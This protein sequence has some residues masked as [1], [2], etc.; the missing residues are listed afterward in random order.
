MVN[1]SQGGYTHDEVIQMLKKNRTI[2]YKYELYDNNDRNLGTFN[3]VTSARIAFNSEST[4]MWSGTIEFRKNELLNID[5]IDYRI[6]P[7]LCILAPNGEWLNYQLCKLIISTPSEMDEYMCSAEMYGLEL[8]LSSDKLASR[9]FIPKGSRYTDIIRSIANN[10][11]LINT[12]IPGSSN[13]TSEDIEYSIGTSKIE[14]INNLADAI[15]YTHVYSDNLG[16]ICC[17]PKNNV[18]DCM[19]SHSYNADENS[20]IFKGKSL[21][22][23][24]FDIPNRFVRFIENPESEVMISVYDNV[25]ERNPFSI[26]ARGRIIVSSESVNSIAN[27]AEL[28]EYTKNAALEATQ[29]T[30]ELIFSTANMPDHSYRDCMQVTFGDSV[31]G[32]YQEYAYSLELKNGGS[33]SHTVRKVVELT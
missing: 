22:R 8:I 25:D 17:M 24:S 1:L 30:D 16:V 6:A 15:N 31:Y 21:T 33:M 19:M 32:K 11:G 7:F 3:T 28:D 12:N 29:A 4:I 27:Q 13:T 26:P 5:K 23:D 18:R 14:I 9:L 2:K 10:S 20:I